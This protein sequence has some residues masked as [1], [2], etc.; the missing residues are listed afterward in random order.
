[1]LKNI[2]WRQWI[3]RDTLHNSNGIQDV[4]HANG[5]ILW[6]QE[7]GA[8]G[9]CNTTLQINDQITNWKIPIHP[10][11]LCMVFHSRGSS[12][13]LWL[14]SLGEWPLH[15]VTAHVIVWGGSSASPLPRFIRAE[16]PSQP[17]GEENIAQLQSVTFFPGLWGDRRPDTLIRPYKVTD[18]YVIV[19]LPS[20]P[21]TNSWLTQGLC[22]FAELGWV[23]QITA[24]KDETWQ[25]TF[26]AFSVLAGRGRW[27]SAGGSVFIEQLSF[28]LTVTVFFFFFFAVAPVMWP[29]SVLI[30]KHSSIIW[31]AY[32][33]QDGKGILPGV[34]KHWTTMD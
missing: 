27:P 32:C 7:K 9:S 17:S 14:E 18:R 26:H 22:G 19:P 29:I 1:M 28:F 13:S 23:L 4:N 24:A 11:V 34:D 30:K 20:I 33:C 12:T 10:K 25:V 3:S 16:I 31:L 6:K 5:Y 21:G 15:V 8:K 2:S